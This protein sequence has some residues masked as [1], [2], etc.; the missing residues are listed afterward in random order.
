MAENDRTTDIIKLSRCKIAFMGIE[1][2]QATEERKEGQYIT[3][4]KIIDDSGHN[5]QL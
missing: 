3:T 2:T 1:P 4:L 5:K